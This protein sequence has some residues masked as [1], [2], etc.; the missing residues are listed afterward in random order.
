MRLIESLYSPS[1]LKGEIQHYCKNLIQ[2]ITERAR[3]VKDSLYGELPGDEDL[4]NPNEPGDL[5]YWKRHQLKDS[6]QPQWKGP[7]QV[8]LTNP[9][10][11]KLEGS[12]PWIHVSHFKKVPGPP[13]Q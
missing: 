5:I 3:L 11:P 9:C 13:L 12:D 10:A 7:Y 6:L 8:L 4:E 2:N 1:L